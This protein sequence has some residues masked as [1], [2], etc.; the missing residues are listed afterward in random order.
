MGSGSRAEGTMVASDDHEDA[1]RQLQQQQQLA[2]EQQQAQQLQMAQLPITYH[3]YFESSFS[4]ETFAIFNI[5][6][7]TSLEGDALVEKIRNYVA[8]IKIQFTFIPDD[9]PNRIERVLM[10]LHYGWCTLAMDLISGDLNLIQIEKVRPKL[11]ES[12]ISDIG[13]AIETLLDTFEVAY[14]ASDAAKVVAKTRGQLDGTWLDRDRSPLNETFAFLRYTLVH[15]ECSKRMSPAFNGI[16]LS[17]ARPPSPLE[18][19]KE[20]EGTPRPVVNCPS[21]H[22]VGEWVG[23]FVCGCVDGWVDE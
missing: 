6:E 13:R 9:L 17:G 14:M 16:G 20:G 12:L 5:S 1:T 21:H 23:G 4:P 11:N 15:P 3:L 18:E 22:Q 8:N 2:R 10:G 7:K 19:E